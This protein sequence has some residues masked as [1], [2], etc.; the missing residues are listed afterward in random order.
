MKLFTK[1]TLTHTSL[2]VESDTGTE[3]NWRTGEGG[4]RFILFC[5]C[6]LVGFFVV[7]VVV[8]FLFFFLNVLY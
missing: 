4:E 1:E 3:G 8:L 6:F 2:S 7:V 5:F